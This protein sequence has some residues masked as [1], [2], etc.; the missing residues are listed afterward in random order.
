MKGKSKA[1]LLD[2]KK[3]KI[4]E[5]DVKDLL[6]TIEKSKKK[7]TTIL[8]DGI[9]TNR[10]VETAD[11][12]GIKNLIGVRKGNITPKPTVKTYTIE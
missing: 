9:I 6:D 1:R 5:V 7:I 4:K 3:K 10:L 12:K 2:E 11:K 8:F